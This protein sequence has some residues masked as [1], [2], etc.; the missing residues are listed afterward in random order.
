MDSGQCPSQEA[1]GQ[2]AG[3]EYRDAS[4]PC[5]DG[6]DYCDELMILEDDDADAAGVDCPLADDF[7]FLA[8]Q[9]KDFRANSTNF[10][11]PNGRRSQVC[12]GACWK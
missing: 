4:E 6:H 9:G 8:Y 1:G 5:H 3:G 11:K 10:S 12:V 2:E 7:A